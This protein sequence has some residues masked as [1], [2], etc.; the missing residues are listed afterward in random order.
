MKART[1]TAAELI[2]RDTQSIVAELQSAGLAL[3]EIERQ[4]G[5]PRGTLSRWSRG[6]RAANEEQ[7][8]ILAA[9]WIT[10]TLAKKK[11]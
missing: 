5:I 4:T 9:F 10:K 1:P 2:A 6:I 8:R 3:A 7:Y 11:I